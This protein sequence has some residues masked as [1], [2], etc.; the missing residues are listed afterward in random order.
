[1]SPIPFPSVIAPRGA[2]TAIALVG[3]AV[4]TAKNDRQKRAAEIFAHV[5]CG[6]RGFTRDILYH[7]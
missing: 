4:A 7:W 5:V 6:H 2:G 1:M 3:L